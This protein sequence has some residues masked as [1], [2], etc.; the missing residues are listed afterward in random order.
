MELIKGCPEGQ[1]ME[2]V[3]VVEVFGLVLVR[4]VEDLHESVKKGGGG[5]G[6]V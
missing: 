5:G 2:E 1:R 6:G 3:E 4:V